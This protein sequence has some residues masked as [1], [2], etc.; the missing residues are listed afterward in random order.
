MQ[1]LAFPFIVL[2]AAQRPDLA[3]EKQKPH[4]VASALSPPWGYLTTI[5]EF[6]QPVSRPI[7]VHPVFIRG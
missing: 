5:Q 3:F 4:Q 2:F 1:L 7:R 6:F